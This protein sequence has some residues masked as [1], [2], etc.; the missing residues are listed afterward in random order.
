MEDY[1]NRPPFKVDVTGENFS[2]FKAHDFYEKF[3]QALS[4][5]CNSAVH[6]TI[7]WEFLAK[8]K[9]Y[10]LTRSEGYS[11]SPDVDLFGDSTVTGEVQIGEAKR[12]YE[13]L[14][15]PN[16]NVAGRLQ[17]P[18]DRWIKSKTSQ[19]PEDK[20]IDL[21]IALEALYLSETDYNRE[22]T[23]RFSLHAAWHLGK[24]KEQRKALMQ[25]FKAIYKWRSMVVHTGKLPKKIMNEPEEA[26]A[27]IAKAQD[28]CRDSI[29]KI[30]ED[31]KFPD[32]NDL[33]LGE[34]SL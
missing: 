12:L 31:G 10:N 33:I 4:L 16:S 26:E 11:W 14:V 19:T 25:E 9:L 1:W 22:I 3:C 27:F 15:N 7:Q 13:K 18:I 30:L 2:N 17:I 29:L 5:T 20:I 24:D 32:W 34:E 28:L 23:F 6:A 8:D 21:G